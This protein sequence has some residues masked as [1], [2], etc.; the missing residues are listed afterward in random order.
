MTITDRQL[1]LLVDLV[2]L[3]DADLISGRSTELVDVGYDA[4]SQEVDIPPTVTDDGRRVVEA[5]LIS[6]KTLTL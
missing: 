3:Q 5:F 4:G 1:A 6:G 2:A